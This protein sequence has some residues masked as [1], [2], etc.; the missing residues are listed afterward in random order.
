MRVVGVKEREF[1]LREISSRKCDILGVMS[2]KREE[3]LGARHVRH[4]P[5]QNV[6]LL[7][8]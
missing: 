8:P 2:S 6:Q 3:N 7:L 1:G 5:V 4:D